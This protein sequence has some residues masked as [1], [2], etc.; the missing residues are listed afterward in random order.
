MLGPTFVLWDVGSPLYTYG[1]IFII[2]LIIW[3]VKKSRQEL[4]SEH[5]KTCCQRHRKVKQ[6]SRDRTSKAQI[7]SQEEAEKL[8]KLLSVMKSQ[9]WL[10]QEG[11]VRRVLCADPGCQICNAM[12]LEIQQLLS[13]ESKNFPSLSGT[14]Q[15][16]E[17][18]MSN[19]SLKKNQELCSQPT[20]EHSP[21]P[22]HTVPQLMDQ[23]SLTKTTSQ[24]SCAISLQYHWPDY[25]QRVQGFQVP[26]VSQDVGALSSSSLEEPGIPE[27][28]HKRKKSNSTSVR[29]NQADP[30]VDLDNKMTFFSHWINPE[31]K[32][33]KQEVPSPPCKVETV[34]KARSEV[35]KN[36]I[37]YKAQDSVHLEKRPKNPKVHS[38][39]TEKKSLIF[40]DAQST[41][42]ISS[43][44]FCYSST[45]PKVES[46]T[47]TTAPKN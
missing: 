38:L 29:K 36:K 21:V 6:R 11:S 40:Y 13:S 27:S 16:H 15:I 18:S 30:E 35:E 2:A 44:N 5:N 14:S 37:A 22:S 41:P 42:T 24:A 20:R 10:P 32:C 4:R 47:Q 31:V 3:Q 39:P 25:L 34:T 1:S 12:A 28:Q 43:N 9:G 17:R 23:K 33:Q 7:T 8:R 45:N 19:R 26:S 46:L